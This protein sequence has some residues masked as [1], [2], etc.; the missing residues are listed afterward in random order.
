M[1]RCRLPA[2][3]TAAVLLSLFTA[4]PLVSGTIALEWE[5]VPGA[6][7][8]R[9]YYGTESRNYTQK[10]TVGSQPRTVLSGLADCTTWYVAVKAY[11]HSGES[12][13]FST[14]VSGWPRP[15]VDSITPAFAWQGDQY[16]M[17]IHGANFKNGATLRLIDD[18]LPHD[19]A[20]NDL[21]HLDSA[22]VLQ[23]RQMQVLVTV[24]PTTRGLRAMEVG[25]FPVT[26]DVT[27]PD[28]VYGVGQPSLEIRF[29]HARW[30]INRSDPES[31]DRIDGA[32]LIWLSYCYGSREGEAYF[33]PDADLNGDGMVDGEDL[34]LLASGF[35]LCRSGESW[36]A[37]ACS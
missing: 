24:E 13:E 36:S 37:D 35:G 3:L 10:F 8:Y 16:T 2:L 15:R 1:H 27:N 25:S 6:Q 12:T 17:N 9:V 18:S 21:I 19:I 5:P 22:D 32:D 20:G 29:D 14:E 34:A 4:S 33:D 28:D 7:G 30:D 31:R 26:L 23:C 11:D